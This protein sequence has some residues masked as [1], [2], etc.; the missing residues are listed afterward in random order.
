MD[1]ISPQA[2]A[3][4]LVEFL[5]KSSCNDGSLLP[6]DELEELYT[7]T[8][9]FTPENTEIAEAMSEYVHALWFFLPL[10]IR[11]AVAVYDAFQMAMDD[12]PQEANDTLDHL[13]S[14]L[15]A[16]EGVSHPA[17]EQFFKFLPQ[18]FQ[19]YGPYI[20][21]TLFRG[22]LEFM[23]ATCLER[24]LFNGYPG[25]RY[26]DY[27]RRMSAQ[28]PV[29]AAI[30]FP[31]SEFPQE[32]YLP[33]IATVEAEMEHFV[34]QVNDLFSFYKESS[35][36]YEQTNYPLIQAACTQQDLHCAPGVSRYGRRLSRA[37]PGYPRR[38]R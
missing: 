8:R 16:S 35:S 24:T 11:K 20:Q 1:Q 22:A 36:L 15:A 18:L 32:E 14:Q 19:H 13:C 25:S 26:P 9:S 6:R 12:V 21:T 33:I 29:Q 7:F 38:R 27:L 30:C 17:W 5:I 37:H 2:L 34:G 23:Q 28:G 4:F 10:D 31:E 3:S